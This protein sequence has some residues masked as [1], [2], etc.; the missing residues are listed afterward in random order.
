MESQPTEI[1][2][3]SLNWC[4]AA[5]AYRQLNGRHTFNVVAGALSDIRSEFNIGKKIQKTTTDNGS[6]FLKA[7]RVYGNVNNNNILGDQTEALVETPEEE[8]PV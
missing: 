3:E 2:P 5:L 6:N 4:S 7:F 8:M 1:D